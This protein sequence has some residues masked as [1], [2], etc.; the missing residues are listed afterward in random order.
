MAAPTAADPRSSDATGPGRTPDNPALRP[1]PRPPGTQADAYGPYF[2]EP[3]PSDTAFA[4]GLRRG[5]AP[6]LSVGAGTFCFVEDAHCLSALV[7]SAGVGLGLAVIGQNG[8]DLPYTQLTFRGGF[9]VRPMSLA[10]HHWHPWSMGLVTSYSVG[11]GGLRVFDEDVV[12]TRRTLAVRAAVLNQLW[13]WHKPHAMH[14]DFSLGAV[15]SGVIGPDRQLHQLWGTHAELALGFGGWGALVVA[16]DFL[17]QDTRVVFGFR[18]HGLVG[19]PVLGV[20]AA[21]LAAGGVL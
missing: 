1:P 9:T 10:R 7:A 17:D 6:V 5:L 20:V 2:V 15:R 13:L 3:A 18:V 16:G 4:K 21:G 12:E 8:P 11:S 19:G 14:L